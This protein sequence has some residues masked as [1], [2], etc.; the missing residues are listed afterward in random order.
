M[1]ATSWFDIDNLALLCCISRKNITA[2]CIFFHTI[3]D[4]FYKIGIILFK[5]CCG[6]CEICTACQWCIVQLRSLVVSCSVYIESDIITVCCKKPPAD[7]YRIS[8]AY[9]GHTSVEIFHFPATLAGVRRRFSGNFVIWVKADVFPKNV[10]LKDSAIS[11]IYFTVSVQISNAG[12]YCIKTVYKTVSHQCH[13]KAVNSAVKIQIS[14]YPA[15][16]IVQRDN[17]E[18]LIRIALIFVLMYI[19]ALCLGF[20]FYIK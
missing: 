4:S 2:V 8:C 5:I 9:C 17:I 1:N 12:F 13:I 16:F 6:V 10:I 15:I 19:C 14:T 11:C 3:Y 7:K 20:S 18:K